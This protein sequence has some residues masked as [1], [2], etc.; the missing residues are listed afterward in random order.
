M[1][2]SWTEE[3]EGLL[4]FDLACFVFFESFFLDASVGFKLAFDNGALIGSTESFFFVERG[5][6][7]LEASK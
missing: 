4:L 1:V 6:R 5:I 7:F 3:V 2:L